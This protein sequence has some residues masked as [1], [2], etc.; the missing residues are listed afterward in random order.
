MSAM[1]WWDS[2]YNTMMD[3]LAQPAMLY[4]TAVEMLQTQCSDLRALT[5]AYKVNQD[6]ERFDLC[7]SYLQRLEMALNLQQWRL[8]ILQAVDFTSVSKPLAM[9]SINQ[10]TLLTKWAK[11]NHA[12]IIK[13]RIR[14][15]ADWE[16]YLQLEDEVKAEEHKLL[17]R[18]QSRSTDTQANT[19]NKIKYELTKKAMV[20][21]LNTLTESG[22]K[23]E[24]NQSTAEHSEALKAAIERNLQLLDCL[25]DR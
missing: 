9:L 17:S 18:P 16:K 13:R 15:D 3:R 12:A 10:C 25:A 23:L 4:P 1:P 11:T 6:D 14:D 22:R 24:M 8:Q 2:A 5:A 21:L 19:P 20:A 7:L